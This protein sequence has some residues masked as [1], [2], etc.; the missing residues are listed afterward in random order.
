VAEI[1]NLRKIRKAKS[2]AES[3]RQAAQNRLR[4]G[5]TRAAKDRDSLETARQARALDRKKLDDRDF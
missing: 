3:E 4:F 2:R 1:V 5:R